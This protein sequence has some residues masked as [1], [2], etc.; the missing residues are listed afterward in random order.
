MD[1]NAIAQDPG[2]L[3]GLS[4]DDIVALLAKTAALH[5]T[6]TAALVRVM[7]QPKP[8]PQDRLLDI[9]GAA[10]VRHRAALG[11]DRV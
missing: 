7:N 8:K 6:V 4:K 5:G 3:A 2:L 9:D 10:A 1:L 11:S